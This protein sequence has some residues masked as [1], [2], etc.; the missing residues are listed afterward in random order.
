MNSNTHNLQIFIQAPDLQS[1]IRSLTL[2]LTPSFT[3]HNLKQSFFSQIDSTN[4]NPTSSTFFTFNGRVLSDSETIQ[5]AG[6]SNLSTLG[7][8]FRLPGGGGDGGATGAESRDCYLNMYADKKPDKVDPNEQR[9]SKWLNCALSNEPLKR[10]IVVDYLGNVFNKQALVEAL[11]MK[12]VPKAFGYIKGLKDMVSVELESIPGTEG[13]VSDVKFQCPVTGLEFNGKYK[14][15]A[16]KSCG[17]VLSAKALKE[18]KSSSCHVCRKEFAEADKIVINGN[19]E[20][21]IALRERMEVEKLKV[22]EKKAKVKKV[23]NGNENVG[24]DGDSGVCEDVVR[25]IGSKREIDVKAEKV[26]GKIETNGKVVNGKNE[27][28]RFKAAD[29]APAN[30]NKEVYASI[31]TSSRKSDFKET[32]SC[33]SLPLGRN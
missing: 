7:L 1:P 9:L 13:A 28:K 8:R 32:Y 18:I 5:S 31:F 33:R 16:L 24:G 25:V 2:T 15:Y 4:Q 11:L 23:K 29:L 6:I 21:V 20:E 30:A 17:H 27:A 3:I 10:P 14:F 26:S 12:N 19:E 22:R